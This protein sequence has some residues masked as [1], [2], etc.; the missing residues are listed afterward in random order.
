MKGKAIFKGKKKESALDLIGHQGSFMVKQTL[1]MD[2]SNFKRAPRQ[3]SNIE[4]ALCI[5]ISMI[6]KYYYPG[7]M[8]GFGW[9]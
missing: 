5:S 1:T 9:R 6:M 4:R 2:F 7:V 3:F 8:C